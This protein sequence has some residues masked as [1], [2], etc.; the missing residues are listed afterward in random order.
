MV[1]GADCLEDELVRA[2][3]E[4]G[5]VEGRVRREPTEECVI[6]SDKL[7]GNPEAGEADKC[8]KT[9]CD[10]IFHEKCLQE[11]II[12][13]RMNSCPICKQ[14]VAGEWSEMDEYW[15]EE[16]IA[17][18]EDALDDE[19]EFVFGR[20]EGAL[21]AMQARRSRLAGVLAAHLVGAEPEPEPEPES[22]TGL[23]EDDRRRLDEALGLPGVPQP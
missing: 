22:L 9:I 18:F 3:E 15:P 2:R 12:N 17:A 4:K 1:V 13:R 21:I 5:P 20:A 19:G 6:C 10:H 14:P 11:W 7:S 16:K 23:S 8:V